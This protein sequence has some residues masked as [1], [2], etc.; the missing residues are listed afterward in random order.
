MFQ[1]PN[2]NARDIACQLLY[3]TAKKDAM[4]WDDL[5]QLVQL[6]TRLHHLR[7][8]GIW[9][10][11]NAGQSNEMTSTSPDGEEYDHVEIN[12]DELVNRTIHL[13]SRNLIYLIYFMSCHVMSCIPPTSLTFQRM[14]GDC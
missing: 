9:L 11:P 2:M 5:K 3:S 4:S 10:K 7:L 14:D 6:F 8:E 13:H 12:L 1:K